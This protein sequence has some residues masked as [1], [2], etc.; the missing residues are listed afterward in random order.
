MCVCVS[1]HRTPE[2]TTTICHLTC[3]WIGA[4]NEVEGYRVG[5]SRRACTAWPS[6]WEELVQAVG[7]GRQA[8]LHP[9]QWAAIV[10]TSGCHAGRRSGGNHWPAFLM[11]EVET[12]AMVTVA[13]ILGAFLPLWST[14]SRIAGQR[15]W[16]K[17]WGKYVKTVIP[18]TTPWRNFEELFFCAM[19]PLQRI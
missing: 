10:A 14:V 15:S 3:N 4:G 19:L 5:G 6:V 1:T 7:G 17:L 12:A 9:I 16:K 13:W 2:D 8:L 18:K 11:P